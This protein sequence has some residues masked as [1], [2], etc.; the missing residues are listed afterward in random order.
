MET[1]LISRQVNGFKSLLAWPEVCLKAKL[2]QRENREVKLFFRQHDLSKT[3]YMTLRVYERWFKQHWP[4]RTSLFMNL[5]LS[6][7]KNLLSFTI[8][9]R[10]SRK[11]KSVQLR[12]CPM[13]RWK[14]FS[15][16]LLPTWN[17]IS[18]IK[19]VP[20]CKSQDFTP[21]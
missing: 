5:Q 10:F 16:A 12:V 19:T 7:D 6:A 4:L 13:R 14:K 3:R 17:I 2:S 9:L 21:L 1:F 18:N 11:G 8:P 15:I 20:S